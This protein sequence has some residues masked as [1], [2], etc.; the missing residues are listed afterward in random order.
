MTEVHIGQARQARP[1]RGEGA[2][3]VTGPT[4]KSATSSRFPVTSLI[5]MGVGLGIVIAGRVGA[6][7]GVL[8]WP[9]LDGKVTILLVRRLR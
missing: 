4:D 8:C 6:S 1:K 7:R 2:R 3:A 5:A 9:Y